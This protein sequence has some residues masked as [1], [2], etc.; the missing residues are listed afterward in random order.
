[1]K[2]C[3]KCNFENSEPARFCMKCGN[4]LDEAELCSSECGTAVSESAASRE[5]VSPSPVPA[6]T[7]AEK[8]QNA[9]PKAETKRKKAAKPTADRLF[10]IVRSSLVLAFALVMF[11]MSFFSATKITA[12]D[13]LGDEI[14][15]DGVTDA[16]AVNVSA[17]DMIEGAFTRIDPKSEKENLA[18]FMVYFEEHLSKSDIELLDDLDYDGK[19]RPSDSLKAMR[20]ATKMLE[21][22]NILK[23]VSTKEITELSPSAS[24]ELWICAAASFIYIALS[25]A[26]L[27]LAA[28][29]FADALRGKK[30]KRKAP[31]ILCALC[32]ASAVALVHISGLVLG[33]SAGFGVTAFI[34]LSV[35]VLLSEFGCR[36]FTGELRFE[37]AKLPRYISA[38]VSLVLVFGMLSLSSASFVKI[39]CKY[40]GASSTSVYR[41][42][43]NASM[44]ASAWDSLRLAAQDEMLFGSAASYIPALF[45]STDGNALLYDEIL[46]EG[47]SPAMMGVLGN[48]KIENVLAVLGVFIDLI[49]AAFIV[50]LA[51]SLSDQIRALG[52]NRKSGLVYGILNLSFVAALLG[53]T[54]VYMIIVNLT[55]E[56]VENVRY[57]VKISGILVTAV[58]FAVADL[59]QKI[60]FGV[61]AKKRAAAV[62]RNAVGGGS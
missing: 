40:I 14:G 35:L 8:R 9:A 30:K 24:L 32:F 34:A 12:P 22:Y 28:V 1:M 4:A 51:L 36:I 37:K 59:I 18:D 52:E 25:A 43:Y 29:D 48:L 57:T 20:L 5:S 60:V 53:L 33:G 15:L 41:S 23:F 10:E 62:S 50:T 26:F 61:L 58:I 3:P 6:A 19:I 44:L 16:I 7:D 39:V 45:Q 21:G 42:G 2:K 47:L 31:F 49:C 17:P 56:D 38:G 55:T 13:G 46:K 11:I 27:A 54:I